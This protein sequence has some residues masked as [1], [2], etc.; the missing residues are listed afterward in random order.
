[1]S[2]QG[3]YYLM[4]NRILN[5]AE[6]SQK[7]S[8]FLFGP[9]STGKTTL[10]HCQFPEKPVINLL[11]SATYLTL[12]ADPSR[13]TD[14]VREQLRDNSVI[15]VDEIQKLPILLDEVHNLIEITGAHFVLT[16]SSAR[17]LRHGGVNLLAGRAWQADLF[18]LVSAEISH[19]DLP[20]YLRFGGLPQV[21]NSS[22]P[23]EELQAYVD[24]YLREEIQAESLVK[25][26]VSF[27]R[28][29]K[30]AGMVNTEQINFSNIAND[31]GIPAS[32]V[33]GYFEILTDTFTGFFLESRKG[34]KKRKAVAAP[35]FYF[36]DVGVANSL[37]QGTAFS[38]GSG[39][40][41][42]AFEHFIA[43]E[44]RAWVSYRRNRKTLSFWRTYTGL[45][46][47]FLVGDDAAIEVKLTR[48]VHDKHLRGLRALKE[49]G[50]I[51]KYFLVSFDPDNRETADGIRCLHWRRFLELLWKHDLA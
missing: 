34:L 36:F 12:A 19:F 20:R 42:K 26:L 4:Y 21:Y 32:T 16:G 14:M 46:V 44:L 35:K 29:L 28:F 24:T 15:I 18:P 6:L 1:M 10:L 48:Q 37:R 41:G 5:M 43:Q 50:A 11:S 17:K 22:Y 25:N 30:T 49:E 9:R 2:I 31:A 39:E 7:K 51:R 3:Y 47:D 13:F 23:E 33:R 27:S 40:Q 38:E 45:E 8:F